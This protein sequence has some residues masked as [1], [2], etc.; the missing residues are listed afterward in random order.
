VT[1]PHVQELQETLVALEDQA[2]QA[3]SQ[4]R[5][6]DFYRQNLTSDAVMVFP[7]GVLDRDAAIE[8]IAAAPPWSTYAIAETR[9][10]ALTDDSAILT[11]RAR[12]QRTG[13]EP[14]AARMSTAFV[15]HE[16]AWKTAFHQQTPL[17]D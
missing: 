1:E 13:Q 11:Y 10:I 16:G 2:W 6:A 17:T 15:R 3:L 12:A 7:F 4:E 14:Y 5:G 8:A 9:V